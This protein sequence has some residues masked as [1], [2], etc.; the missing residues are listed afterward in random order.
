MSNF[1]TICMQNCLGNI[2]LQNLVTFLPGVIFPSSSQLLLPVYPCL[3]FRI[4]VVLI[5]GVLVWERT[6]HLT[7]VIIYLLPAVFVHGATQR[8]DHTELEPQ[9]YHSYV[10]LR[11]VGVNLKKDVNINLYTKHGIYTHLILSPKNIHL[12]IARSNSEMI[13]K[14]LFYY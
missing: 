13:P 4:H 2:F 9:L 12:Y 14:G 8:P 11:I 5:D 6:L 1:L 7:D 3:V 10:V